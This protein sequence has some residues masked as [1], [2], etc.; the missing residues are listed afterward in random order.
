MGSGP[1]PCT[2][3]GWQGPHSQ[4][5]GG[6]GVQGSGLPLAVPGRW[7]QLCPPPFR[8]REGWEQ[9]GAQGEQAVGPRVA[10]C[11]PLPA[12]PAH[13]HVQPAVLPLADGTRGGRDLHAVPASASPTTWQPLISPHQ[14]RRWLRREADGTNLPGSPCQGSR[15][16]RA[17]G[18]RARPAVP[19]G[20]AAPPD[21]GAGVS[22]GS[23]ALPASAQIF[24]GGV[25][26]RLMRRVMFGLCWARRRAPR[27]RRAGEPPPPSTQLNSCKASFR[28]QPNEQGA[29]WA[30]PRG[31]R[32]E[33]P[34][35]PRK[36]HKGTRHQRI[37]RDW[38]PAAQAG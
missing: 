7:A 14:P 29:R 3:G 34:P 37:T 19:N 4:R 21:G 12:P 11:C 28:S 16:E 38:V 17:A 8:G 20:C 36:G 24:I 18:R 30:E 25:A 13:C 33:R 10:S 5:R 2:L 9:M 6:G 32:E 31:S 1:A 22:P 27:G 15:P 26:R 23:T 35:H